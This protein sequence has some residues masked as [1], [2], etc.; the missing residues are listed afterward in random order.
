M[1]FGQLQLRTSLSLMVL[2]LSVATLAAVGVGWNALR[3][4]RNDMAVL[5]DGS[6]EAGRQVRNAYQQSRYASA[7]EAAQQLD[8]AFKQFDS[9]LR[10]KSADVSAAAAQRYQLALYAFAGL[11]A[12]ALLLAVM[13]CLTLSR[14]VLRPLRQV[15]SHFDRMAA[16][17]LT[18]RIEVQAQNEIGMLYAALR[19]MQ[20]SLARIVMAVRQGMEQISTGSQRL[21]AGNANLSDR[22]GEQATALQ[23]TA[24]SMEQL[25]ST[26][27]QNADNARQA[28]Q[29]AAS[30]S[31]V[32]Q[33]GGKAVG[34]VVATMEKISDSSRKIADIVGVI[35]SI[36]FQ[37]NIL[38]LNAAVEAARAG[39]QGKGFA[40][41]ASEV[42]AL[43]QRSAQ[44][45][46]EI[47][48]LIEDS[49]SKITEGSTQVGQAGATMEEIVNSVARVTDIMGEISAA[50]TEQSAGIEQINRAVTQMDDATQQNATLVQEASALAAG[51]REQVAQV[52]Q[53][54]AALKTSEGQIIDVA[55]QA[56][57]AGAAPQAVRS[58]PAQPPAVARTPAAP[59]NA[60]ARAPARIGQAAYAGM[61]VPAFAAAVPMGAK[62]HSEDDWEEF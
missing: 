6:L 41:V 11:V 43:A 17:D 42:R 4:V 29:L 53:A 33:R 50:T 7:D 59:G 32:A 1:K 26:V 19:R 36:A 39:E 44:A 40:V 30:A 35:D 25:A 37:T 62:A 38:A 48:T 52:M 3:M 61:A 54:V 45:A 5:A 18:E 27:R 57:P 22:T 56:L 23:Q 31:E 8:A 28:N 51:L 55:A 49:V 12:L 47:K 60:A 20:D 24:A 58:Q 10:G 34:E 21:V 16:G 2:L 46:K 14:T 15:G 9:F 13:A